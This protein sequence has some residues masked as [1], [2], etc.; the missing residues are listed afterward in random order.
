MIKYDLTQSVL[1]A[2]FADCSRRGAD[3]SLYCTYSPPSYPLF[4]SCSVH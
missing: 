1:A 3:L 4:V 2:I